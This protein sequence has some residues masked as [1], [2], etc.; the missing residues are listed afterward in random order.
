MSIL[1]VKNTCWKSGHTQNSKLQHYPHFIVEIPTHLTYLVIIAKEVRIVK[2]VISCDVFPVSKKW[3][4]SITVLFC[5]TQRLCFLICINH[6]Y[7]L[8]LQ[9]AKFYSSLARSPICSTSMLTQCFKN[10]KKIQLLLFSPFPRNSWSL[11]S[12]SLWHNLVEQIFKI[13]N[14]Q[15]SK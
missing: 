5:S 6:L 12:F 3:A 11:D 1:G 4:E 15:S 2:G 7:H 8:L 9:F 14:K 10:L 13:N